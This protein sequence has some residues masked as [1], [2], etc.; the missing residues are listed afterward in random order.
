MTAISEAPLQPL[1]KAVVDPGC[2]RTLGEARAL[3]AVKVEGADVAIDVEL[4]YPAASQH[5]GLR[6]ALVAAAKQLPGVGNVSVSIATKVVAHAVQRGVQLLPGV[7]NIIA[8]A[9]GK[10]GVG[11]RTTAAN[12]WLVLL[13]YGARVG[14]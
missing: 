1:L 3:K 5:A 11:K 13:A 12:L 10:G 9:S 7:K 2:G 8:V 4:G 14:N 6:A